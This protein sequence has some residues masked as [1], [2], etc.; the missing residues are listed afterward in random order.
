M[1]NFK[2]NLKYTS[3]VL[4]KEKS[5]KEGACLMNHAVYIVCQFVLVKTMS[6]RLFD[7]N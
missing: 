3:I 7:N 5:K 6:Q 4:L 1:S 2:I